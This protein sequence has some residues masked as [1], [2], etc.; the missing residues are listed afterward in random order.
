[1]KILDQVILIWL[2]EIPCNSLG[3][4]LGK[5][6]LESLGAVLDFY[7]KKIC[8]QHFGSRRTSLSKLKAGH[9]SLNLLPHN[10]SKWPS[11]SSQSWHDVGIGGVCEPQCDGKMSWKCQRLAGGKMP[12]DSPGDLN[13]VVHYIPEPYFSRDFQA[14]S[15]VPGPLR[16]FGGSDAIASNVEPP[17]LQAAMALEGSSPLA[18]STAASPFH[19]VS[20]ADE[21]HREG[22]EAAAARHG[23]E[24]GRGIGC[25]EPGEDGRHRASRSSGAS[26]PGGDSD[27]LH[28]GRR[29]DLRPEGYEGETSSPTAASSGGSYSP[30]HRRAGWPELI[31]PRGGLP[32]TKVD[33][34]KLACL[35]N[36]TVEDKDTNDQIREKIKPFIE[37]LMNKT[38]S[39]KKTGSSVSSSEKEKLRKTPEEVSAMAY[40]DPPLS[41]QMSQIAQSM[42]GTTLGGMRA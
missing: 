28:G 40:M 8:W 22:V 31:G 42:A 17:D 18:G 1:M 27:G 26:Q 39:D 19:P 4:L 9:F 33:L 13:M 12:D 7:N 24:C 3:C 29:P 35:L 21:F 36:I 16:T 38:K 6:L 14:D 20:F 5:D 25:R 11:L 37:I 2:C 41:G 32:R 15:D 10:L 30:V 23:G 34:V